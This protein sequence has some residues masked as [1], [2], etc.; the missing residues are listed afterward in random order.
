LNK[1]QDYNFAKLQ[2]II[3]KKPIRVRRTGCWKTNL[4]DD[5]PDRNKQIGDLYNPEA[6]HPA[7]SFAVL[8]RAA[9]LPISAKIYLN[10]AA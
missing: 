7:G 6:C 3:E 2:I 9:K 4:N 1:I 8:K 10:L 5:K